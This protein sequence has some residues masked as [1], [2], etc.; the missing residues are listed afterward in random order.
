MCRSSTWCY[1]DFSMFLYAQFI[2]I[3]RRVDTC[4]HRGYWLDVDAFVSK[5]T[6][7][8]I[9]EAIINYLHNRYH[10][11]NT[12]VRNVILLRETCVAFRGGFD[13]S[14]IFCIR[15]QGRTV[16]RF[17]FGLWF[18]VKQILRN[19]TRFRTPFEHRAVLWGTYFHVWVWCEAFQMVSCCVSAE[20]ILLF[21]VQRMC[22]SEK[23]LR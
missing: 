23:I 6:L 11:S 17:D 2:T 22:A 4:W 13:G 1:S 3:R 21:S 7:K 9:S 19:L 15:D 8:C 14:A 20:R 16:K 12:L 18:T 5:I 10:E